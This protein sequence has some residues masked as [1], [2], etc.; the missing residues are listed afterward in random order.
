MAEVV[1]DID[2]EAIRAKYRS[3]R[4]KRLRDEGDRQ[5]IETTG[6]MAEFAEA[7]PY[8]P[9]DGARDPITQHHEVVIIGGGFGGLFCA[10]TLQKEG[11]DDICVIEAGS[12]FG[13]TWYW[14]RYPGCR[15]D[16][17]SYVYIPLLEE[18][19]FMPTERYAKGSEIFEQC[20]R[21]ANKYGLYEHALFQTRV[22]S[23]HW[24]EEDSIW[25]IKTNRDDNLTARFVVTSTGPMS[26]PRLPGI[27]GIGDFKG[28]SFHT[29][30]WDFDY[31]GGDNN[32]GLHKLAGKKVAIIGT[33]ST[34]VQAIPHLAEGAEHLYVFQRTPPAVF[35][36]GNRPTDDGWVA[37]LKPGWQAER[38]ENF[39]KV[40]TGRP[41]ER[42]MV[43]DCWTEIFSVIP[44]TTPGLAPP[45]KN[46]MEKAEI[47]DAVKMNSVRERIDSLVHKPEIAEKLKPWFRVLCKRPTFHDEYLPTYNRD[48]VTLVDVSECKGIQRITEKGLVA[49]DVEY[50]VDLIVFATG[51]EVASDLHRR[52]DYKTYGIGGEYLM[53]YWKDGRKTLHGHSS[54]GFP[55]LFICGVSQNGLSMNFSSM[56]GSQAKHLA[57]IIKE[58][59]SRGD[60]AAVHPT[61]DAEDKWVETIA[62][63]S[64]RNAAFLSECTPSYFNNDGKHTE[65]AA[66]FLSDAYAPGIIAFNELMEEWREA[67]ECEG[68][69]FISTD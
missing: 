36:R 27:P 38:V 16:I 7:D 3:E 39:N 10:T 57:Y 66:G 1:Q 61:S 65:R 47:A 23:I 52:V 31:T 12:D 42:D 24:N 20:Q 33:A 28:H 35:P 45:D 68:L 29:C 30:R 22:R 5:Y 64:R 48:N 6:Q 40:I 37:S 60:K 44:S 63:L 26:K 46:A 9:S 8:A 19:G 14:N 51:Y 49:N 18:T 56:Y 17:E 67:G 54:H 13:G 59:K 32:G 69:E 41:V 62:S 15:C 21:I 55:N 58:V 25:T 43:N 34:G 11:I 53:D 50:E 2:I 4:D